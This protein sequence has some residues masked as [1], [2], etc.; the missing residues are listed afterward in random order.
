MALDNLAHNV[1]EY[2][3][4]KGIVTIKP[5][6]ET[7]W[8]DL[9]NVPEFEFTPNVEQLEHN[10]SRQG[11][12]LRDRTVVLSKGGELRIVM[13]EWTSFNLGLVL[14]GEET[15]DVGPPEA[16]SIDIM[17]LSNFS[18][19][20]R[21]QGANDVGPKWNFEFLKVDFVPSSSMN[22]ISE[23]WGT[24]EITGQC[25]AVDVGSGVLSFGTAKR[26]TDGTA[27]DWPAG[28]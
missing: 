14:M 10:S 5:E 8:F 20:V 13:E 24:L 28:P 25:A 4:G 26:N 11:V 1:E 7:T 22:P 16:A 19:A 9:G 17:S 15:E 12:R 3:I 27:P 18:C 21:F 6:G 23:E 2:Y